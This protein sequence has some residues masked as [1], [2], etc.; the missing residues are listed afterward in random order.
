LADI[1]NESD[2]LSRALEER[3]HDQLA[4][5]RLDSAARRTSDRTTFGLGSIETHQ[6]APRYSVEEI[7]GAAAIV[8]NAFEG[9]TT[10]TI[11]GFFMVIPEG[12]TPH[13]RLHVAQKAQ[14]IFIDQSQQQL[15][16]ASGQLA[17]A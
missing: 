3:R 12:A 10:I 1:L 13:Q 7:L 11:N 16:Q 4:Q 6:Y 17:T 15:E 8:G 2:G 14:G 5:R 9:N